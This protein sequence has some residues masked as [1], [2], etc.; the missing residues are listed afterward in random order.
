M[1]SIGGVRVTFYEL[2]AWDNS[3]REERLN[4]DSKLHARALIITNSLQ[5]EIWA[6]TI[7]HE[8]WIWNRLPCK[9]NKN[10]IFSRWRKIYYIMNFRNISEL[11]TTGISFIHRFSATT[12]GKMTVTAI[13][14]TSWEKSSNGHPYRSF[15]VGKTIVRNIKIC[16]LKLSRLDQFLPFLQFLHGLLRPRTPKLFC[17]TH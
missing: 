3:R 16:N 5:R 1:K 4:Q 17:S 14:K 12:K 13:Y 11:K 7:H 10:W 8:N 6:E 15:C 2:Y 9:G